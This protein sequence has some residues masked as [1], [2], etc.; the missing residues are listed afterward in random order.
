MRDEMETL[1]YGQDFKSALNYMVKIIW[2][3]LTQ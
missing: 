2:E 1:K 3:N